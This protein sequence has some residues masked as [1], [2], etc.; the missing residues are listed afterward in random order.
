MTDS[1][2]DPF[3]FEPVP[4][5]TKR[6]DGWTPERQRGFIAALAMVGIVS[7]AAEAVGMSRKTAYDLLKRAGPDSEFAAAWR[8]AQ[9]VGRRR[10]VLNGGDRAL[11]GGEVPRFYRGVQRGTRRVHDDRLLAAALRAIGRAQG[12]SRGEP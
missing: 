8:E 2:P 11:K 6:R 12:A 5:R 9:A 4:S 10:T 7:W 3:A 1:T